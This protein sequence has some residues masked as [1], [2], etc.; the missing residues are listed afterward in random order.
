MYTGLKC[1]SLEMFLI[2]IVGILSMITA[3]YKLCFLVLSTRP[4]NRTK[5]LTKIEKKLILISGIIHTSIY[6]T[7]DTPKRVVMSRCQG[8]VESDRSGHCVIV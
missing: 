3:V 7:Y 5:M 1:Y 2:S 4:Y 6:T 8:G